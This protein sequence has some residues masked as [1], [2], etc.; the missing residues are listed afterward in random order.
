[1][2]RVLSMASHRHC[3][4]CHPTYVTARSDVTTVTI[5][6]TTTTNHVTPPDITIHVTPPTVIATISIVAVTTIAL[7][8]CRTRPTS[9]SRNLCSSV[10]SSRSSQGLGLVAWSQFKNRVSGGPA[11]DS[12]RAGGP[13]DVCEPS[14]RLG[15]GISEPRL[16]RRRS[17]PA[18]LALYEAESS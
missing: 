6:V 7:V 15:G 16:P 10:E 17:C 18:A 5:H 9:P 11:E 13:E 1:M 4:P 14:D 3:Q 12:G 2:G 8:T